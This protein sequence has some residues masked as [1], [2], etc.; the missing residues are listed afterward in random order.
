MRL[1]LLPTAGSS[2]ISSLPFLCA[3]FLWSWVL[4]WV[5]RI[6]FSPSGSTPN[7]CAFRLSLIARHSILHPGWG[8][9]DTPARVAESALTPA[10]SRRER[11]LG[12][13]GATRSFVVTPPA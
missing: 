9:G 7:R 12:A 10:L 11:E 4:S 5:P 8:R 3:L 13:A 1:W 2:V 6:T